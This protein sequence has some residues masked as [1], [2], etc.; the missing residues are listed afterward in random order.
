MQNDDLAPSQLKLPASVGQAPSLY[1][2]P[3][4]G[5]TGHRSVDRARLGAVFVAKRIAEPWRW[6]RMG[7]GEKNSFE[8][9]SIPKLT[10][11]KIH[12]NEIEPTN[13]APQWKTMRQL[14]LK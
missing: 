13:S 9:S 11:Q 3:A 4:T 14:R 12:G 7:A 10:G 1:F 2:V 5:S 8:L 6:S